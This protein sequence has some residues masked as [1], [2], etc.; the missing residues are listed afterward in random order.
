MLGD[1]FEFN[2]LLTIYQSIKQIE[3]TLQTR[4]TTP[5]R[6]KTNTTKVKFNNK[7]M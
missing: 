1:Q 2:Y 7:I 4:I 6:D 3:D 5:L